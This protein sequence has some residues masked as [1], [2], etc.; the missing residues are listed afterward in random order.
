ME[1]SKI[2]YK[3]LNIELKSNYINYTSSLENV[4]KQIEDFNNKQKSILDIY[5]D[6]DSKYYNFNNN[7]LNSFYIARFNKDNF[8]S[9]IKEKIKEMT[10]LNNKNYLSNKEI[11]KYSTI[12]HKHF[13]DLLKF[14]SF[15][16][17]IN[18][19]N[20]QNNDEFNRFIYTIELFILIF[21]LKKKKKEIK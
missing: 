14:E 21:Q 15:E 9:I 1:K 10:I 2:E 18:F 7:V 6:F 17:K 8:Y 20:V 11:K 3:N 12:Y 19:L 4:N 13:F 16:S 5:D